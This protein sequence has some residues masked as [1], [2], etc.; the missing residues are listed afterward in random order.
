MLS[1]YFAICVIWS[2]FI[3]GY[4][5][6]GLGSQP[7]PGVIFSFLILFFIH[8]IVAPISMYQN[9]PMLYEDWKK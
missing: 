1:L 8:A 5:V 3:S 6:R 2:V 7:L 4:M 9:I